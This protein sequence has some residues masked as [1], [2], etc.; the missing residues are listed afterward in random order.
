[1]TRA[2]IDYTDRPQH[3]RFSGLDVTTPVEGY[4]RH[5]LRSGG[6]FGVVRIWYGPPHDP[7]TGE[8]MDRSWRW[9]AKFNG[10]PVNFDDVWPDC[11]KQAVSEQDYRRAIARQ[12][13][14]ENSAPDS[15]YAD[16]RKRYDPLTAP[17]P[18]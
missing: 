2:H 1:M 17:L 8:V 14:A 9:Q 5:R 18:F 3:R 13:W 7:V 4:Y 6:V 10:E 11:A 16:P 15:A 12:K